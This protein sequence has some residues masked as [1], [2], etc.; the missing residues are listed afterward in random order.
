[1]ADVVIPNLPDVTGKY[2]EDQQLRDLL[3]AIKQTL[4]ILTGSTTNSNAALIDLI[5][6]NQ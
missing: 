6:S 2:T 1:M 3:I 5:N 4:E